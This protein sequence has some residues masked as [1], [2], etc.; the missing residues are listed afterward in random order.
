MKGIKW[1]REE[2]LIAF[3]L[4]CKIPFGKISKSNPE[5]L[6]VANMLG[7]TGRAVLSFYNNCCC[8]TGISISEL[9][10]ASHIKP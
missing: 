8:M 2:T 10:I 7:R 3:A 4:Y 9:L 5:I 6:E 1:T